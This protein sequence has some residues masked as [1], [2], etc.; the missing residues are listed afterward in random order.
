MLQSIAFEMLAVKMTSVEETALELVGAMGREALSL[1]RRKP[2]RV[3]SKSD[4]FDLVTSVDREIESCLRGRIRER[5]PE[6]A[7]LG[8]EQDLD[9]GSSEW[10]WVLDPI[11]GTLNFATGLQIAACSIALLR[12]DRTRV[13]ALGE[14]ATDTVFAARAGGGIQSDRPGHT[15]VPGELGRVRLFLDFS[16]ETPSPELLEALQAFAALT[17]VAPRMIGSAAAALLAV[18]IGGG[19]FAGVGLRIWDVAAGILLVEESGRVVRRWSD[20]REHV[21][22]VLAGDDGS[23]ET[24]EPAMVNLI[25][26]WRA[27]ESPGLRAAPGTGR[28]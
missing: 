27:L 3:T 11:D 7:I 15:V 9:A 19:C 16:P 24:F 6:H 21:V 20:D 25:D 28:G 4:T 10:T 18:A 26:L 22:H 8:E 2:D 17:P 5:F 23:V 1:A 14:L 12:G 13:A